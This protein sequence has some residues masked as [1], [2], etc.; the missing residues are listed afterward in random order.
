MTFTPN[1]GQ[2]RAL[3]DL[4][5]VGKRFCLI[6]GGSRSGKTALLVACVIDRALSSP[7]SRHLIVR[8][9]GTAAK[10]AI[11][12][13]TLPKVWAL[14]YPDT[15]APE[16]KELYGYFILPNGSEIWIGG[17]NDEKAMER[18][19]GNEYATIYTNEASEVQYSAFLLLRSRL[20][21]VCT[22][23]DGEDLPQRFYADLNP[24]TRM[25]WTYRLW[26]DGV[27][28]QDE[29]PV[30]RSRYGY[31][32]I[33]PYDNAQNL[34]GDYLADL[35][36]LPERQRKRFLDGEYVSD[37][38]NALWKR[39]FFKRAEPQAGSEKPVGVD[40]L[41]IVVAID[42]AV[43]TNPGSDETGIIA[44]ALGADGKG[45]VL[46][47]ESGK[48][49]PE[50]WAQLA[51]ALYQSL[52]ADRIVGEVNQGGDMIE[53]VIRA[54]APDVPYRGVRASRG[55]VTRAEPVAA[56]YERGKV[57]HVGAF[58]DLEDQCCAMTVGFDSKAAG[59]SPDRV[60]ALV[61]A[62]T[63]LFPDLAAQQTQSGPL[64]TIQFSRV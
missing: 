38:D 1:P 11:V 7:G 39:S 49:R 32:V 12:K 24:T 43:S 6:Y 59:W 58:P 40:L 56:L 14:K 13:D 44:A 64:P 18:I 36:A 27:D 45:Y 60:D 29:K 16:W 21:Q 57:F 62:M 48:H 8:K 61:W 23:V 17:L 25:H 34:S 5:T 4:L 33:N 10:R 63:D 9:E 37:D 55:K 53:A 35:Q 31:C 30:D 54:Q 20:A 52:G 50:E 47:D 46:A 19:L 3:D 42:P 22:R 51:L 15:P 41:R 28:P 26:I 2:Q